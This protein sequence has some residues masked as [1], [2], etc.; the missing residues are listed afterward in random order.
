MRRVSEAHTAHLP[1]LL[2]AP[3]L[4]PHPKMSHAAH[5]LPANITRLRIDR[6]IS[7]AELGRLIGV[8]RVYI[9]KLENDVRVPNLERLLDLAR[10]LGVTPNDLLDTPK[11]KRARK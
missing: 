11:Q 1:A 3:V 6:G 9:W 5:N 8:S 7:G 2:R 10:A 4:C